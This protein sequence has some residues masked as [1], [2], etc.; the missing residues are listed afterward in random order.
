MTS[1]GKAEFLSWEGL[2]EREWQEIHRHIR[3]IE[4]LDAEIKAK[5]QARRSSK[6]LR[7]ELS[8][9]TAQLQ[10]IGREWGARPFPSSA[11]RPPS[12]SNKTT[13]SIRALYRI[14]CEGLVNPNIARDDSFLARLL[15][16]KERLMGTT[17][18]Q[19]KEE[20]AQDAEEF[21]EEKEDR[22]DMEQVYAEAEAALAEF[23]PP[24]EFWEV[25]K[26]DEAQLDEEPA[27]K[28]SQFKLDETEPDVDL[29]MLQ[30][31]ISKFAL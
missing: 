1:T 7:K 22:E 21:D 12:M 20:N 4:E 6:A 31:R 19:T 18:S 8:E 9:V 30:S 2:E 5:E 29:S 11:S 25:E 26:E 23:S 24:P 3:R 28:Y 15:H 13:R 10:R 16:E 14:A 17:G 27:V